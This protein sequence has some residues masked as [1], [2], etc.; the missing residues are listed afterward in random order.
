MRKNKLIVATLNVWTYICT[1]MKIEEEINQ[2]N[3]KSEFQKAHINILFT[4]SWLSQQSAALL[5]S[6]NISWQQFNILRILRGMYP[7]P[8]SVKLL[9][10][11]M[12]DKMSNASRLVEKLKQKG[13]VERTACDEDRRK[14]NVRI[15]ELGLEVLK[16]A[17]SVME[18]NLE[19]NMEEVTAEEAAVLNNILD[20][21]RG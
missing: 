13:L 4:A 10:E 11:R 20:K 21:M 9:T 3:F 12:I 2:R 7:E 6:F 14:V 1:E 8:A 17:S 15:T 18:E 16:E 5:K 19:N